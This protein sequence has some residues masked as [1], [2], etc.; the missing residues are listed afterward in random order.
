MSEP[1][2]S[3][4]KIGGEVCYWCGITFQPEVRQQRPVCPRC[5]RLLTGAGVKDDEIF[6]EGSHGDRGGGE[7]EAGDR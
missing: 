7:K 1:S 4:K 6:G 3:D 2:S 5:Y